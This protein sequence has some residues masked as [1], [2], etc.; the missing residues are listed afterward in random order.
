MC[1]D[2]QLKNE[3]PYGDYHEYFAPDYRCVCVC[4]CEEVPYCDYHDCAP[5]EEQHLRLCE[6]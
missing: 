6:I 4:V 3:L 2:Q 1:V 5:F